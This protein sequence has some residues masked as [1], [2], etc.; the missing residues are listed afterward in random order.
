MCMYNLSQTTLHSAQ[1]PLTPLAGQTAHWV[2]KGAFWGHLP[3]QHAQLVSPA[4]LSCIMESAR[5]VL[6]AITLLL[7]IFQWR[8][9]GPAALHSETETERGYPWVF[10]HAR[11]WLSR[12]LSYFNAKTAAAANAATEI[13][14]TARDRLGTHADTHTVTG[15]ILLIAQDS[16]QTMDH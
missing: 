14:A 5:I 10:I 11:V 16:N 8:I 9:T 12:P 13:A 2:A 3:R 6:I 7:T 4:A 15:G 1:H